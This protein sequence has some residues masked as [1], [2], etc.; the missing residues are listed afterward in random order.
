MSNTAE[1]VHRPTYIG[2]HARDA[3]TRVLYVSSGCRQ[4]TG[5]TPEYLISK[6]AHEFIADPYK[7]DYSTIYEAK[8]GE[9]VEDDANAYVMYGNVRTADGSP[10]LHRVTSF[11]CDNCVIFI[12]MAFPDLPYQHRDELEVQMLDG[13]KKRM[14]VTRD[15]EAERRNTNNHQAAAARW[16]ERSASAYGQRVPLYYAPSTQVKVAFVLENPKIASVQTEE[17][18]RRLNGPLVVFVTG[19]VGRLV[20]ADTA[21][22][23][24]YPFMKL[25]APEDL[26]RVSKFF[27]RLGDTADVLFETFSLLQRPH[28]I[29]GDIFVDDAQN[30]RVVV[31][32]LGATVQDGMVLLLRKLRSQ[33]PPTKDAMGNYVSPKILQADEDSGYMTL[34]DIISDDPETSDAAEWARLI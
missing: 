6:S 19:S 21:D 28:I 26:L 27:D 16:R 15:R 34:S 14:N 4:G 11:K 17:S 30:Q 7:D 9:Q 32:C 25:V 12:M 20:D 18:A 5:Y 23:M 22:L 1:N 8:D 33:A 24:H 3:T 29:D 31:E 2:I 13:A 10:V